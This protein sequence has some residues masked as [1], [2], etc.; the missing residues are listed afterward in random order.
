MTPL[1]CRGAAAALAWPAAVSS[2]TSRS[3]AAPAPPADSQPPGVYSYATHGFERIGGRCRGRHVYP[4]PTTVTV[5]QAGCGSANAGTRA[6]S[7]RRSG[8]TAWTAA[9]AAR[10][11]DRL[12]RV[13]RPGRA[14]SRTAARAPSSRARAQIE[15]GFAGPIAAGRR[16]TRDR[17]RRGADRAR[18]PAAGT[19]VEAV[20]LRVRTRAER[21]D[22]GAKRI[23]SWLRRDNGLLVRR[24]S[25][26]PRRG[27]GRRQGAATASVTR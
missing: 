24:R 21:P 3:R 10:R 11:A 14:S 17:P 6:P 18:S 22:R 1:P 15:Q 2:E 20:H 9:L 7:A 26:A 4:P 13:L 27:L 25:A 23:D 16:G 5:D 19:R 12:P 8:A